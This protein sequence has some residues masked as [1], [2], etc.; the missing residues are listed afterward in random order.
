MARNANVNS[1]KPVIPR[2]VRAHVHV[3]R[4]RI[5]RAARGETCYA[6]TAVGSGTINAWLN[7]WRI[8]LHDTPGS[9]GE[10]A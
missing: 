5:E 1:I 7:G 9:G 6:S 4:E 3:R 8:E 10:A 2:W